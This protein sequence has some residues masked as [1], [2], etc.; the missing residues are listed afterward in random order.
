MTAPAFSKLLRQEP[1]FSADWVTS[2]IFA[3]SFAWLVLHKSDVIDSIADNED[4]YQNKVSSA[5]KKVLLS[6]SQL[7]S[8]QN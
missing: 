1:K 2:D 7:V 3:T 5:T 8:R 4:S 6:F